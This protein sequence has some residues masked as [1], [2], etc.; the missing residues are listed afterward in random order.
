LNEVLD[1]VAKDDK[2][3]MLQTRVG[4]FNYI[5]TANI[6]LTIDS[7]K[8]METGTV[9]PDQA[10][11]IVKEMT[12]KLKGSSI[13]RNHL[14]VLDLI[15]NTNWERPIY[16]AVTVGG[17][18]YLGLEKYF[19][20]EGLAYRLVPIENNKRD[21][22]TGEVN[23]I[24]MYENMVKKF[25]WGNMHKPEVYH[26]TET[27]RMSLNYRSMFARLA[28]ALIAEGEKEKALEA[29]DR[30]MEVMPHESIMLNF[31]AAGIVEAYYKLEE[32]EKGND[33]A[34][35]L[36]EV[37]S[38]EMEYYLSLPREYVQRL[39]NEP[40]IA[41]S[42]MQK[43]MVLSRVHKQEELQ[44]TIEARLDAIEDKYMGSPL[45]R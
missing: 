45:S 35:K 29:L 5:P 20:V 17:D 2:Q 22:Q 16:F 37:Y 23:H 32:F 43:L 41:M 4:D 18:N 12:W 24:A 25:K 28:N 39:G 15:A 30:C 1:F 19:K 38:D 7:A 11:R 3:Y 27:V 26:G 10:D 21:G 44:S 36:V 31:S 8:V 9:R 14:M 6:K 13:T 33:V 34:M 40:D 42:V